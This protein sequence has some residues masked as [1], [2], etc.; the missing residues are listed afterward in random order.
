MS[1]VN[2]ERQKVRIG[3]HLRWHV[4]RGIWNE[5]CEHCR[6]ENPACTENAAKSKALLPSPPGESLKRAKTQVLVAKALVQMDERQIKSAAERQRSIGECAML[7][8]M[9]EEVF[10]EEVQKAFGMTWEELT[11]RAP[12]ALLNEIEQMIWQRVRFGDPRFIALVIKLRKLPGW[13]EPLNTIP[14]LQ[15]DLESTRPTFQ[16]TDALQKLTNDEIQGLLREMKMRELR[17]V[18]DRPKAFSQLGPISDTLSVEKASEEDMRKFFE[19]PG[20]P[21]MPIAESDKEEKRE[22]RLREK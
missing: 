4:K 22:E 5:R 21:W 1:N 13:I 16:E 2:I 6:K 17:R 8:G 20:K 19:G 11:E 3:L 15:A 7:F 18:I 9:T 12:L 14:V 10:R